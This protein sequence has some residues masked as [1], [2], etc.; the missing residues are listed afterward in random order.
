MRQLTIAAVL[1]VLATSVQAQPTLVGYW[2]LDEGSG[3]V[4]NDSAGQAYHGNISGATWTQGGLGPHALAF[5][6][7]DIV[8]MGDRANLEPAT[9]TVSA[10]LRSS[11]P[12]GTYTYIVSEGLQDP[13]VCAS[14]ALWVWGGQLSFYTCTGS[15]T[16]RSAPILANVVFDGSW[17]RV[18]STYDGASLRIFL[19]GMAV[20]APVAAVAPN[21]SMSNHSDFGIGDLPGGCGPTSGFVGDI[22][23]VAVWDGVL[24]DLEI[25]A[26][27]DCDHLMSDGLET[28]DTSVWSATEP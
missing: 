23:E 3:L 16:A 27:E 28:G 20:G 2:N 17:H 8:E 14:Y 25:E 26:L 9:M 7:N 11:A 13:C 21:Y 1:V 4:A 10:C 24:S 18:V 22:D 5:A 12:Q 15:T 19:D 6:G